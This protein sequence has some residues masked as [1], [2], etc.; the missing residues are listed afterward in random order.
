MV[1]I[2]G[3]VEQAEKDPSCSWA[4]RVGI[5]W[6][7]GDVVGRIEIVAAAKFRAEEPWYVVWFLAGPALGSDLL[8]LLPRRPLCAGLIFDWVDSRGLVNCENAF[9]GWVLCPDDF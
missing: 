2:S 8:F 7:G 5:L 1:G 9:S 3:C 4:G 6:V